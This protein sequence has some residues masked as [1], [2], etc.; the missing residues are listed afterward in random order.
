[1]FFFVHLCCSSMPAT[2]P[3]H[4]YKNHSKHAYMI[5][6]TNMWNVLWIPWLT[7]KELTFGELFFCLSHASLNTP[8]CNL[9]SQSIQ[10]SQNSFNFLDFEQCIKFME[11]FDC[12]AVAPQTVLLETCYGKHLKKYFKWG[13]MPK[14]GTTCIYVWEKQQ[15][16]KREEARKRRGEI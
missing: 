3:S 2:I 4:I 14:A 16:S 7:D 1:M 9:F 5:Y 13:L 11:L 6:L 10:R 15:L 8:Y 12:A